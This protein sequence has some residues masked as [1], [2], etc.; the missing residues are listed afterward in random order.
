M[1]ELISNPDTQSFT[2][3]YLLRSREPTP[4]EVNDTGE[5]QRLKRDQVKDHEYSQI[6][7]PEATHGTFIPW[8]KT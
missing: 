1:E 5:Y 4:D 6:D 7:I 8:D 3:G 2:S